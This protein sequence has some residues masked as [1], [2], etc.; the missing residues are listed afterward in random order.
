MNGHDDR[1]IVITGPCSIHD[2]DSAIEYA[3]FLKTMTNKY[4]NLFIIMRVYFEKPR[5]NIGWK[6]LINDPDL[7]NTFNINKGIKLARKL[8]IDICELGL[9]IGCEF[10]DTIIPQYISDLVSWGAIGARTVESQVHRELVSGLSMPVGFKNSTSGN[11]RVALDSVIS[12]KN[13]HSFLGITNEGTPA[14][15]TTNG[16]E[17]THIILRGGSDGPNYSPENVKNVAQMIDGEQLD[18]NIIIDCS[19]G[20][21][22]KNHKN[23]ILV[24]KNIIDQIVHSEKRIRGIMLE[25]HLVEGKQKLDT[26]EKLLYGQS[27]TDSCIDLDTTEEIFKYHSQNGY[28]HQSL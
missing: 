2:V 26:K 21:S 3:Q 1:L 9:P 14:I 28:F 15:I 18:T 7:N 11:I 17:N 4:P 16:N 8:L 25:S 23:Q 13:K 12:A 24:A 19:H 27:I 20:N 10:L 6:G 5:T 22:Q